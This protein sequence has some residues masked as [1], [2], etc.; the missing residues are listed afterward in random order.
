MREIISTLVEGRLSQFPPIVMPLCP[1]SAV[2]YRKRTFFQSIELLG[3]I[4]LSQRLVT[5]GIWSA[6]LLHG[7]V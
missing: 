5:P 2:G 1:A 7:E 4:W 6:A 3:V